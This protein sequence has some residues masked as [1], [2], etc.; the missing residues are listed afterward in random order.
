MLYTRKIVYL[1]YTNTPSL[2]CLFIRLLLI[3]LPIASR[4]PPSDLKTKIKPCV[5]AFI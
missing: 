5:I 1:K 3:P 4:Q 2:R